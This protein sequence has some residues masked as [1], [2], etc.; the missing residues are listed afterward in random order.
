M[1]KF[2]SKS[3]IENDFRK[4]SY[5][6][7]PIKKYLGR[8]Y[9]LNGKKNISATAI[10]TIFTVLMVCHINTARAVNISDEP[11]ETQVES[12]AANIM[13]ILDNS[14]SMDWEFLT[15]ATDGKFEGN[16]EYLFDDP[17]D[18]NYGT[19]S[20]NGTI[21]TGANR[22]KWKSQWSGYNKVYYDP[23]TA[24]LPW[25]QTT[26]NPHVDA[27]ISNPMSNPANAT[28]TFD[29][30]DEYHSVAGY[31]GEVIV[32]NT[33]TGF[34]VSDESHWGTSNYTNNIGTSYRFNETLTEDAWAQWTPKLPA[35]GNYE[36]YV[37][38]R[39]LASRS[40]NISYTIGHNGGP[41]TVSSISQHPDD[42]P[43]GVLCTDLDLGD[44]WDQ[45]IPLGT[46][47]FAGDGSDYVRLNAPVVDTDCCDYSADAIKFVDPDAAV[48]ATVS[49]KNAHYYTWHDVDEDGELDSNENIYMI[50]FIDSD[51]DNVLDTREYYRFYDM[52]GDDI[53]EDGEL[54]EVTDTAEQELFKPS[55]YDEDGNWVAYKTDA[56]DLQNFANWYQYYRRRELTA[57][58][59]VAN[60]INSLGGVSIGLYTI[61]AGVR[62]P[63]LPIQL[64]MP[65]SVIVDNQDA[66]FTET[67]SWNE[68]SAGDEYEGSSYYTTGTGATA[69]WTPDLPVAGTYNVYAWWCYWSTRDTNAL[70]TVNHSGGSASMRKNQQQTTGQWI[71][72]G[73]YYFDAGTSG[74]VTVTR[75]GSSTQ[76]S[77]SADAVMFEQVGGA[78]VNVDET[79][80][81]LDQLYSINSNN[82]TPLRQALENVGKYYHQDDGSDGNLGS[83]P[84]AD[85]LNG[86]AC[87]KAYAIA[88]TD[89]Y[90]NGSD[91]SVANAD[92][93][94]GDP[95]EDSYSN[96]LAD[97]AMYYY[98]NDLSS[99]LDD[100]VPSKACDTAN[101]QHMTTYTLSFG[102]TGT[103]DL[104][105][106]D[107]DGQPDPISYADDPCFSN[108]N[109]PV[110]TW[111]DPAAGNSEK[112]DDLFHAAVNGR[113][114]FF[115][116]SNPQELVD[117]M[118]E[119]IGDI[120]DPASG[121][122]V[123]VNGEELGADTVL[124]QAR[125]ISGEWIGEVLAFPIDQT[126]GAVL[127]AEDQ[128]L[129]NSADKLERLGVTWDN[130][131]ILTYDGTT[132]G[133][134][135]F[136]Y[137]EL[138][139]A[140]QD[141]LKE[142]DWGLGL[143][144]DQQAERILEYVR[145]RSDNIGALNFRYR[146]KKLGD[147]VHSAP[148]LVG[149][150]QAADGDFIDNDDDGVVDETGELKGATI[151]A[152]GNDGMLHA[153]D[154]QNGWERFA[155]VPNLVMENLRYLKDVDYSH[156]FY[157]DLT[158]YVKE[159]ELI[160]ES[161][162]NER[163]TYLVGGL[164]KGGKGYYSLLLRHRTESSPYTWT[165]VMNVD[166][167]NDGSSE[168]NLI[169][170][171]IVQWEYPRADTALDGMDNNGD[172]TTDEAG[173]TDPDIG[174]SF[175]Q[176]F[177]VKTNSTNAD[178]QWVV[179]FGNGYSSIGAKAV[180]YI[181]DLNGVI[182]RKI[183]TGVSGNNGLS[184]PSIV[185]VN[186]DQQVDYVY[187]G[188]LQGNMWK[189]DLTADD[190]A[191]WGSA[192][193]VDADDDDIIDAAY[194]DTPQPLIA[195]GQPITA[196]P[197]VMRHCTGYGYMVVF[198]TGKFLHNDDRAD[199]SQQTI[200]GIWDY[201]D[202]ADDGEYLGFFDPN[203]TPA[204]SNQGDAVTLLE[205]T[206]V[207]TRTIG[208]HVYR[209]FS[210]NSTD[211]PT[212][213]DTDAPVAGVDPN[214][215]PTA[216]AGWYVDFPNP[217]PSPY[218]YEGERVIKGVQI[219][220]GRAIV[221]SFIPDTSPCSG[222]G[223]S[224]LYIIDACDGSRMPVD[225]KQFKIG[226]TD[227]LIEIGTDVNG[228]PI[229]A[230]PTGKLYVGIV[231]EPKIIRKP[232]TGDERLYMSS[233][234]GVVETE[235]VPAERRG[236]LY[237]LER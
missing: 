169:A 44:Q 129:W 229:M 200:Y 130:R 102:V 182:I 220:D 134:I 235:D 63:V 199:L 50:N 209:T 66:G 13:F 150:T 179:I 230:P 91:P 79:Y 57:K 83:S 212:V 62:Q 29:L 33:D 114:L 208:G 74:S 203:V 85:A 111:P 110:P 181:L 166:N 231:H 117:G 171:Q 9:N 214:P 64:D 177:I 139:A 118:A 68:S 41:T 65:A 165:D 176:A 80:T 23:S 73:Q 123:S 218:D 47:S 103:I 69:T 135:K 145:G 225:R 109:T 126:T 116:A 172:G 54:F 159:I 151:F 154:A 37:W 81:L 152:G 157:V 144:Q 93:S 201:G 213:T 158:P 210:D 2:L 160:K 15:D 100:I 190:A 53:V 51:A 196:K 18:N 55:E 183:D 105:D 98:K 40:R 115:S 8:L 70:Y 48:T 92:D 175:S 138:T 82:S 206:I 188:D 132:V 219:R 99:S 45:W 164:G 60:A 170:A 143:D 236:T 194:G 71:L 153:F 27:D 104:T 24:Y 137:G 178:H 216:H 141:A 6:M 156:K 59:V 198:G 36:V 113:G 155:Y 97:V 146:T 186:N 22:S 101:H 90:W 223:N 192:Y 184:T 35:A 72:L 232:G 43:A 191:K 193:G 224:F 4:R 237:W 202:D 217:A 162:P 173:E 127:N 226:T 233:S 205:Q 142:A 222:G 163:K 228:N 121:A 148:V 61:N 204:L 52:D 122:S 49:I 28:P 31:D 32:D 42:C 34:S 1:G 108:T 187:A 86:G 89:G 12:A 133:G 87:Q 124:Y 106:M 195:T 174:Y 77:T 107:A 5:F 140:Q 67:G 95:Y 30:T 234:T 56:E 17:G 125:Y 46:F 88:M 227:D 215:N 128:V 180:L 221:I 96:T 11:M 58:A 147:I 136:R 21:L 207:D 131:R 78:T 197:D 25:P 14:G 76:S 19:G 7:N 38:F 119:I 26:A 189:F 167:F 16:I 10:L 112:I 20:S 211:W 120:R 168:D 39:T 84:F 75:D 185:D 149:Q 94:E 3:D 161:L